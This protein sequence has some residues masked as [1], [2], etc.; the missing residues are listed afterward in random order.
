MLASGT[1]SLPV[2][3]EVLRLRRRRPSGKALPK[4]G[5][6]ELFVGKQTVVPSVTSGIKFKV[7]IEAVG[8]VE[9]EEA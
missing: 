4:T 8:Q 7:F 1:P 2:P 6:R 3:H 5:T 9:E